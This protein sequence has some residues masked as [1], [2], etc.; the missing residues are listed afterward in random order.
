MPVSWS[1]SASWWWTTWSG[2]GSGWCEAEGAGE[3]RGGD[4]RSG[5]DGGGTLRILKP[6]GRI[7]PCPALIQIKRDPRAADTRYE[8]ALALPQQVP[9]ADR[10]NGRWPGRRFLRPRHHRIVDMETCLIQH[11]QN[12]EVVSRVKAI[13]RKQASPPTMKRQVRACFAM[14]W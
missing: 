10:R 5:T 8:R 4:E 1:G 9:G 2:S 13:G 11:E 6:M 3:T 14:S 12:D 7:L